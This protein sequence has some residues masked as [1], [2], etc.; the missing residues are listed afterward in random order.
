[1]KDHQVTGKWETIGDIRHDGWYF[2]FKEPSGNLYGPE[3]ARYTELIV[4]FGSPYRWQIIDQG[5]ICFDGSDV[6]NWEF[7]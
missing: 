2:Q 4:F 6:K 3:Y 5:A 1:M 7:V